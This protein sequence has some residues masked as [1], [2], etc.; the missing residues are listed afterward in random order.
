M[1]SNPTLGTSYKAKMISFSSIAL[2]KRANLDS[3]RLPVISSKSRKKG[4]CVWLT[5]LA[6]GDEIGGAAVIQEIFLRL[7]KNPLRKGEIH[8]FPLMNPAGFKTA[9]R[10]VAKGGEDLNRC[11]PGSK[12]GSFAKRL[13]NIIFTK[14]I[15]TKPYLVI[16]LHTGWRN[17]IPYAL[18]GPCPGAENQFT[19]K[20]TEKLALKTG[21]LLI[22]EEKSKKEQL[23]S[24]NT[25]SENF[26]KNDI[27]S[28]VL[29]LG[30]SLV[31]NE[32]NVGFGLEAI[33][34]ILV[35]L[36]MVKSLSKPFAY[37]LP[38][39]L[40]G[41]F[42]RYSDKGAVS[43]T[44]IIRFLAKPGDVVKKGQVIAGVFNIL[45]R[46]IETITAPNK[47]III[48]HN[49]SFAPGR[50]KPVVAFGLL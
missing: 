15:R 49:D 38:Q 36:G 24:P 50:G 47:G 40:R 5:A 42:C 48:E 41:R 20:L 10:E 43:K 37:P 19:C 26:L 46:E 31:V 29:E 4:P 33:W 35:W 25:L 18:L 8:A 2:P 1:G 3:Q 22:Q 32:I 11:F 13:A 9:A 39:Q 14:I 28:F 30:E 45:G 6:H 16:D 21:L 44:G 17:S 12:K 7:K 27:A 23:A 34:N